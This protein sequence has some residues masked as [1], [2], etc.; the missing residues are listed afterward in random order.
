[1]RAN[2]RLVINLISIFRLFFQAQ[3]RGL[4]RERSRGEEE[5]K[6]DEKREAKEREEE[7]GRQDPYE[8]VYEKIRI[9]KVVNKI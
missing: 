9:V 6:E 4:L 8:A 7:K 1:M 5:R 3:R 2:K